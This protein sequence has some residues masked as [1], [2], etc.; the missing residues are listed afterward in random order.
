MYIRYNRHPERDEFRIAKY[1]EGCRHFRA[2]RIRS[3]SR[4]GSR[5]MTSPPDDILDLLTAYA[6]GAISRMR[7]RAS[8]R[9]STSSPNCARRWPNC[10]P[11]PT[12]CPM[13]CLEP[14]RRPSCAS[15][16]S[17]TR[18]DASIPPS[19]PAAPGRQPHAR[20][21]AGAERDRRR[22]GVGRRDRLGAA[23]PNPRSSSAQSQAELAQTP[24]ASGRCAGA[25][26]LAYR[27]WAWLAPRSC[28]RA[29]AQRC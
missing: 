22:G 16:C 20:L 29:V 10:A 18:L 25:D 6:L 23:V 27:R 11:P 8:A 5:V 4:E 9:C 2:N 12:C 14:T 19:K 24:R 7:S 17:T 21:G 13:A 28:A 1:T 15:A 3:R 26:R